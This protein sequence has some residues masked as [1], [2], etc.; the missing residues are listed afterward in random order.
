MRIMLTYMKIHKINIF[1]LL[2]N[3]QDNLRIKNP[4]NVIEGMASKSMF[5]VNHVYTSSQIQAG[6]YMNL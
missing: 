4:N 2:I 3:V 6:F 5:N 1:C